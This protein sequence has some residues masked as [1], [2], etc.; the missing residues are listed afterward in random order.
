[1]IRFRHIAAAMSL[2]AAVLSCGKGN[3]PVGPGPDPGPDPDPVAPAFRFYVNNLEFTPGQT[4]RIAFKHEGVSI[5]SSTLPSGWSLEL[6]ASS[7]VIGI[8]APDASGKSFASGGV[9]RLNGTWNG[10]NLV[11]NE[12]NVRLLGINTQDDWNC[13]CE[14]KTEGYI[15]DGELYLNC[16]VTAT[17]SVQ[18]LSVPFEAHGHTVTLDIAPENSSGGLFGT[19]QKDVRNL[20]LDGSVS[21]AADGDDAGCAS[22]AAR[23]ADGV[24]IENVSSSADVTLDFQTRHLG[25]AALSGIVSFGAPVLENCVFTGRMKALNCDAGQ[26]VSFLKDAEVDIPTGCFS[27][28][29]LKITTDQIGNSYI[30]RTEGGKVVVFDGGSADQAD[31]LLKNINTYYGG[32]IDEWWISHAHG[33]HMGAFNKIVG[34]ADHLPVGKVVYSKVPDKI[35]AVESGSQGSLISVL[36]KYEAAGGTV[37]DLR[38]AGERFEIDGVFIKVLG[39]ATDDFPQL[40]SPY[41]SPI[42]NSSVI[43]RVWD[44]EKSVIFLGD[45]Q[46]LK[47]AKVLAEYRPYMHCDYLQMGHHGNWTCGKSFYDAVDF[48][49]ALWPTPTFLWTCKS[50]NGSG[51]DCWKYRAWVAA[52][53]VTENHASCQGDWLLEMGTKL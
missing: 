2:I 23:C 37:V 41:P 45:A 12:L 32:K 17:K 53:G 6:D 33:D 47:G 39:I 14:G 18:T 22:L 38:K 29:Q 24:R 46:E 9:V 50:G 7:D 10:K 52:K 21:T 42:N 36:K 1:M 31:N 30:L 4:A 26:D 35:L 16:D 15:V 13:F 19:V 8:V 51:W 3:D 40:G 44:R 27:L 5:T 20:C 28:R 34:A 48:K 25:K 49:A 43:I 11:S